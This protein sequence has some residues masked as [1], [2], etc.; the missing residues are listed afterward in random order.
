MNFLDA[1]L[2]QDGSA[3]HLA[4]GP[5]LAFA[6]GKR[7]GP[8]GRRLTIGIRPEH[9]VVGP[10]ELDLLVDLVEPTGSESL[11]HGHLAMSGEPTMIVRVPSALP[12]GER[13]AL[14]VPPAEMHVFDQE[15]GRRL[16]PA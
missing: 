7:A 16:D 2:T 6:D 12:I 13:I 11:V 14:Q 4:A 1:T 9:L 10:G 5:V 15:T 3:A 8:D